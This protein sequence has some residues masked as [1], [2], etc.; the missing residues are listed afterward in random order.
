MKNLEKYSIFTILAILFFALG[1]ATYRYISYGEYNSLSVER[2][3]DCVMIYN[4]LLILEEE[5]DR[6]KKQLNERE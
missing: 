1:F 6:L 4:T 3:S 5:N 2:K